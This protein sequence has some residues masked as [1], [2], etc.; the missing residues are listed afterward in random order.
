MKITIRNAKLTELETIK[1]K[2]NILD[3]EKENS[4]E[5]LQEQ[6]KNK[7]IFVAQ[8]DDNIVGYISLEFL[9][10][11]HQ[12]LPES[13]FIS[14]LFILPKYRKQNIGSQLVKFVLK[15]KFS[16]K[17]KYFSVTHDPQEKHLTDFYKKFGFE[18]AGKTKALNI[19]L[20]KK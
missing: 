16:K 1:D 20:F 10:S 9:N 5:R 17:Y 18:P 15:Q 13:I 19:K 11:N 3:S 7:Q 12:E 4:E 8:A 14:E 2:S 6:I